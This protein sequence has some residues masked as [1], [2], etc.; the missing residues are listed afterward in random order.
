MLDISITVDMGADVI[1]SSAGRG[2]RR[3][4][5]RTAS[6]PPRHIHVGKSPS[7]RKLGF[8]VREIIPQT[9]SGTGAD[10]AADVTAGGAGA[11]G[12]APEVRHQPPGI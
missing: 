8:G 3:A 5:R 7:C 1:A 4:T 6:Q 9:R 11:A 2:T 12:P 10:H